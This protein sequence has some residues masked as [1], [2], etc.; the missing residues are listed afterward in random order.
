[1]EHAICEVPID[2]HLHALQAKRIARSEAQAFHVPA[3]LLRISL[4]HPLQ[5]LYPVTSLVASNTSENTD[6]AP[7]AVVLPVEQN[8]DLHRFEVFQPQRMCLL[9][10]QQEGVGAILV[11]CR[12]LQRGQHLV[13][14]IR[15]FCSAALEAL[16]DPQPLVHLLGTAGIA[17]KVRVGCLLAHSLDLRHPLRRAETLRRQYAS[18]SPLG[19]V[20]EPAERERR[21]GTSAITAITSAAHRHASA[22]APPP[23]AAGG[24]S[25]K[26][27]RQPPQPPSV[28][29]SDGGERRDRDHCGSAT[30]ARVRVRGS[31]NERFACG[32]SPT[33]RP[34]RRRG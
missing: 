27:P 31:G 6:A 23:T 34:R 13:G 2:L 24:L 17:P 5:H 29:A 16:Q 22:A 32:A 18:R 14:G 21:E 30:T 4:I 26:T 19:L 25:T 9:R 15:K 10:L 20:V 33:D 7:P 1:M 11:F 3:L 12:E 8:L 28:V